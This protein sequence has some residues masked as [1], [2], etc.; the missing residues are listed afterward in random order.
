MVCKVCLLMVFANRDVMSHSCCM[1]T[2]LQLIRR[3][4]LQMV[5]SE[6]AENQTGEEFVQFSALKMLLASQVK[7][8]DHAEVPLRSRVQ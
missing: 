4:C 5:L 3:L 8:R 6:T 7:V 2:R 1:L